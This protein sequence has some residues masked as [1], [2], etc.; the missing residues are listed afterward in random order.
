MFCLIYI[1]SATRLMSGQE[2]HDLLE[3][4]RERNRARG[5][6]GMLLYKGGNFMQLLEGDRDTVRDVFASIG[7]DPRH[8][9]VIQLLTKEIDR[10]CFEDWSM[11]FIDMEKVSDSPEF[12]HYIR[13]SLDPRRFQEDS[14]F[15]YR[16]ITSFNERNY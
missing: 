13:Q 15:A 3:D 1:S 14:M 7:R 9:D 6:T 12:H 16:F 2:L 4:A 11:G 8:K 5:I 10:R